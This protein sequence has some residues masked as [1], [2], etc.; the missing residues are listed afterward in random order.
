LGVEDR[1]QEEAEA[2]IEPLAMDRDRA[3]EIGA[4]KEEGVGE[5]MA[6]SVLGCLHWRCGGSIPKEEKAQRCVLLRW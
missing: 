2:L 5:R 4:Q 3:L 1:E 6:P